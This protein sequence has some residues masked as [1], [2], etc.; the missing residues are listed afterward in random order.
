MI[1]TYLAHFTL[2][3]LTLILFREDCKSTVFSDTLKLC[4]FINVEDQVS[5]PYKQQVLN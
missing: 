4:P 5:H 2:E 1:A 3:F